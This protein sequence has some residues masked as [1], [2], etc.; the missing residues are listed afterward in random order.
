MKHVIDQIEQNIMALST[1]P[2]H[3]IA[4]LL[5]LIYEEL[6]KAR[7]IPPDRLERLT[8]Y[9][10]AHAWLDA[11]SLLRPKGMILT[12]S[13]GVYPDGEPNGYWVATVMRHDPHAMAQAHHYLAGAALLIVALQSM[14]GRIRNGLQ[15]IEVTIK[16]H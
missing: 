13:E 1:S 14:L 2:P 10:D 6:M 9:I 8:A 12:V 11:A 15:A 3:Q 16:L 7:L 5:R 4:G